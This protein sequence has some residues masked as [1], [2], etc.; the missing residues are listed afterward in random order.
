MVKRIT[1]IGSSNVDFIMKLPHLPSAGETV[2]GGEYVQVFGGKGANTATAAARAGGQ[3][4]FM[5]CLGED[6]FGRQMVENFQADQMDTSKVQFIDAAPS[7]TALIM[8]D[9]SGENCISVAAGANGAL[10]VDMVNSLEDIIAESG[11]VLLQMEIPI[12]SNKEVLRLA[13][14]HGTPVLL[15]YAPVVE[16]P[17]ELDSRI[18]Y[19]IVNE[20]EATALSGYPISN[21]PEASIA[22]EAL[23]LKGPQNVLVTLG[24][25]GAVAATEQ[26]MVH[27]QAFEVEP[28]DTTAA[29]D[30]FCGALGTAIVEGLTL[31]EAMRQASAAAA[32]CV[33]RV[34]A[35]P[36][37]PHSNE[38]ED[39]LAAP[40]T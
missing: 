40:R 33:T 32:L 15:N 6:H 16:E 23:R 14:K 8:V 29:G 36:S 13:E 17:L 11:L 31:P 22:A 10:S 38:I 35:Q 39:F 20:L 19:L 4:T 2:T 21:Q 1:V 24:R 27:V 30:T 28:V 5:T 26:G 12:S 25:E 18:T 7:G 37:I 3:V 9:S 34:G